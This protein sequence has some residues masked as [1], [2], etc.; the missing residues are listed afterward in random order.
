MAGGEARIETDA[1]GRRFCTER[2]R[3]QHRAVDEVDEAWARHETEL[4]EFHT[5]LVDMAA[6]RALGP[7]DEGLR[8]HAEHVD[9]SMSVRGAGERVFLEP[10]ARIT[11]VPPTR[12]EPFDRAFFNLRWG[13]G[14][15]RRP[16]HATWPPKWDLD[17]MHPE[18]ANRREWIRRH[19]RFGSR[20]FGTLDRWLGKKRTRWLTRR[21]LGRIDDWRNRLLYRDERFGCV[22]D[23]DVRVVASPEHA[24]SPSGPIA[25]G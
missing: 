23:P 4:I 8:S 21:G 14:H 2:H 22:H 1:L 19:R 24:G 11:Y 17:P 10:R 12:L 13:G 3:H 18:V 16:R 7:L 9:F 15:G 5:V 6:I 20:G 25:E